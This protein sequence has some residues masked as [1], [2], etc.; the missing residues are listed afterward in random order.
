MKKFKNDEIARTQLGVKAKD[1]RLIFSSEIIEL[2][3]ITFVLD[4]ELFGYDHS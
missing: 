2:M 4:N 3:W 1:K